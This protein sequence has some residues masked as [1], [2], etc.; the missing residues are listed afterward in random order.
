MK[1]QLLISTLLQSIRLDETSDYYTLFQTSSVKYS[2]CDLKL[3]YMI[4]VSLCWDILRQLY[5][6]KFYLW[7]MFGNSS[8]KTKLWLPICLHRHL[9]VISVLTYIALEKLCCTASLMPCQWRA[10]MQLLLSSCLAAQKKMCSPKHVK[11]FTNLLTN[12][13]DEDNT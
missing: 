13:S 4:Y 5:L 9:T 10:G 1:S 11:L 2:L 3:S 6:V 8:L 12:V 7:L